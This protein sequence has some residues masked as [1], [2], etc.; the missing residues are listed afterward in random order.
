MVCPVMFYSPYGDQGDEPFG[1]Q[2]D[3]VSSL[4]GHNHQDHKLRIFCRDRDPRTCEALRA[5]FRRWSERQAGWGRQ[6]HSTPFKFKT[7]ARG[8]GG[9]ANGGASANGGGGEGRASKRA[10]SLTFSD[11]NGGGGS[12]GG[13]SGGSQQQQQQARQL[14]AAGADQRLFHSPIP[15]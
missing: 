8:G 14:A 6:Q 15:E 12:G 5:A 10:R 1:L 13:S 11:L 9:A 7:A 3:Q 4:F 2:Q